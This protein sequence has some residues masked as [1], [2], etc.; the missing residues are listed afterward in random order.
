MHFTLYDEIES[1]TANIV[2]VKCDDRVNMVGFFYWCLLLK[3]SFCTIWNFICIIFALYFRVTFS[4]FSR[5]DAILRIWSPNVYFLHRLLRFGICF[6]HGYQ[7]PVFDYFFFCKA[8][9][10]SFC[11]Q[12]YEC[13]MCSWVKVLH[14][15]FYIFWNLNNEWMGVD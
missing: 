14:V 10:F 3:I 15:T 11:I 4:K 5:N 12:Q 8:K 7:K 9:H 13:F 1:S 6:D 2:Q